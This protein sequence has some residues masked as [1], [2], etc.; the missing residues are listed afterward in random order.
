MLY[1]KTTA[2]AF[3]GAGIIA[4]AHLFALVAATSPAVAQ[5]TAETPPEQVV[6]AKVDGQSIY[7][8]DLITAYSQLP[9]QAQQMGMEAVYPFLLDRVIDERL[10][11]VAAE[12]AIAPDDP[13]VTEQLEQM[14]ERISIQVYFT[15]TL[16]E[17]VTEERIRE[18]YDQYLKDNP[19]AEEV[20][21]RHILLE[22]E[23]K[24]REV[25]TEI[26]GGKDF[27]EAAKE[28]S[29]G[30]SG[31]NGG[32]LGYFAADAMVKPFADA[33]FAMQAGDISSDPVQTQFGWHLIKVEDRRETPQPGFE[34]MRD[35]ISQELA[36]TVATELLDGL[37]GAATIEKFDMAGNPAP[38][39]EPAQQ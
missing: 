27:A 25:L 37:R 7:L 33:A 30:P 18:G 35:Q 19:P 4:A 6:V 28:H 32:D 11:A 1:L 3:A 23:E 29:T 20:H 14:R 2:G 31:P 39:G 9:A 13:E 38:E 8:S 5:T 10:L 22:T 15:R 21:A 36:Q 34:E 26:Q 12:K 17:K 16:E 24:A